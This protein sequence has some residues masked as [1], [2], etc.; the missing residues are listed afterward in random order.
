VIICTKKRSLDDA[1]AY[2]NYI[3][4]TIRN[5]DL[6]NSIDMRVAQVANAVF[7]F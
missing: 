6:F 5:K 7:L 4:T 1:L 2:V 3:T